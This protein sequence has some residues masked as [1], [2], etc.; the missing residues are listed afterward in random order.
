MGNI[1]PKIA[2]YK[3]API[4]CC[5]VCG[6]VHPLYWGKL[7]MNLWQKEDAVCGY[8]CRA[9]W[10]QRTNVLSR[11]VRDWTFRS[12]DRVGGGRVVCL[13]LLGFVSLVFYLLILVYFPLSHRKSVFWRQDFSEKNLCCPFPLWPVSLAIPHFSELSIDI[14]LPFST[15]AFLS[16]NLFSLGE[17]HISLV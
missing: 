6:G 4:S 17:N 10:S 8:W 7:Q 12:R 15:A 14:R 13:V 5:V 1:T 16:I 11:H 9:R 3:I 2:Q